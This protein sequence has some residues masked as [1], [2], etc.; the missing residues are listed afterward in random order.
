MFGLIVMMSPKVRSVKKIFEGLPVA[1]S[2]F[3]FQC[4]RGEEFTRTILVPRRLT[5]TVNILEVLGLSF[6]RLI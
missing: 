2:T 5:E 4:I 1:L 6:G 3:L